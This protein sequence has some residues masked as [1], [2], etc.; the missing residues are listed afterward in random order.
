M[1]AAC[2]TFS[3]A[4]KPGQRSY[5]FSRP[6]GLTREYPYHFPPLG[7]AEVE[8]FARDVCP[9]SFCAGRFF[10]WKNAREVLLKRFSV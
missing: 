3:K 6:A 8:K 1:R 9:P 4:G 7:L 10:Y 2:S 5:C